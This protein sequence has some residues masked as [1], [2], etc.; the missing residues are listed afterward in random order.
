MKLNAAYFFESLN[1]ICG[2]TNPQ[3]FGSVGPKGLGLVSRR[4]AAFFHNTQ[5]CQRKSCNGTEGILIL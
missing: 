2:K 5:R 4:E 1:W 3:S